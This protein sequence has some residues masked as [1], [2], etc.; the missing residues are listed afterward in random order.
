MTYPTQYQIHICPVCNKGWIEKTAISTDMYISCS[1]SLSIC[2]DCKNNLEQ[3]NTKDAKYFLDKANKILDDRA[4]ER[5]IEKERSMSHI[6][7][8]YNALTKQNMSVEDGWKFLIVLK[9]VRIQIKP[10]EDGYLDALGYMAL[11]A[12]ESFG[13]EKS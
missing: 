9:L 10:H 13:D 4:K 2:S 5:D 11:L 12:E 6:V 3:K 1:T 7:S 8:V